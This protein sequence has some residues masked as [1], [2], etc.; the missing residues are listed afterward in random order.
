MGQDAADL[1]P[2]VDQGAHREGSP[3][4]DLVYAGERGQPFPDVTQAAT[5]VVAVLR[6]QVGFRLWLVTRRVAQDMVVLVSAGGP[7]Q[8]ARDGV[9]EAGFGPDNASRHCWDET[10]CSRMLAGGAQVVPDV[11]QVPAYAEAPFA[12][13]FGVRAYLGAPL[14]SQE[15]EL[16]GTLCALDPHPQPTDIAAALPLVALQARLLSTLLDGE[17]RTDMQRRRAERAEVEALVDPLTGAVNRRAWQALLDREEERCRRYGDTA[18]VLALDLDDLKAV[19][20]S[21]GHAAGDQLLIDTARVLQEAVRAADVVAR[22]GGDEF[23]VLAVQTN[24]PAALREVDRLQSRLVADGITAS[25]G[26][27][28]REATGSLRAAWAAADRNMYEAKR[29]R[30]LRG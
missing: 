21:R 29:R 1:P 12:V 4:L 28:D 9:N 18:S 8:A 14:I 5:A 16:L 27:A 30:R 20:D 26:M 6:E 10:L 19:N 11:Q 24:G 15:G 25:I 23:A 3:G 22:L 13:R 7:N 17:L 2:G